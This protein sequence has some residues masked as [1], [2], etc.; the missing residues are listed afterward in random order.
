[1]LRSS[2][3]PAD[4]EVLQVDQQKSSPRHQEKDLYYAIADLR[5]TPLFGVLPIY[6][7]NSDVGPFKPSKVVQECINLATQSV[8]Q[9]LPHST[10]SFRKGN[11]K[12]VLDDDSENVLLVPN[13][14]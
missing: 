5:R 9:D 8:S 3:V 6:C 2:D 4:N 11:L 1:M 13:N 10:G 7:M 12:P 14:T